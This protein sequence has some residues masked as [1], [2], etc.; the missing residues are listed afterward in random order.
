MDGPVGLPGFGL[1]ESE[2]KK[3]YFVS[4]KSVYNFHQIR[5]RQ[6]PT[7]RG[8]TGWRRTRETAKLRRA[9]SPF[10]QATFEE[11]SRI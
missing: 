9:E 8:E 6:H 11:R 1:W 5:V 2:F 3:Y 4:G 10:L 7:G